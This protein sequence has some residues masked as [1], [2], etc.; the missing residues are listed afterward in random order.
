MKLS[1]ISLS[2]NKTEILL[3]FKSANKNIKTIYIDIIVYLSLNYSRM[4][5]YTVVIY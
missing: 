2:I 1:Q 5:S 4:C 3:L